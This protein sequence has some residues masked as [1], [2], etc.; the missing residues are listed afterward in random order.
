MKGFTLIVLALNSEVKGNSEI[1][2]CT[3]AFLSLVMHAFFS[4]FLD[5]FFPSDK[6][7]NPLAVFSK[8]NTGFIFHF[9]ILS[10]KNYYN[11]LILTVLP[12][13]S[14]NTYEPFVSSFKH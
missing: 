8:R 2:Y 3:V 9:C 6:F 14:E 13:C 1:A 12:Q 7:K 4:P 10:V 5:D 11:I